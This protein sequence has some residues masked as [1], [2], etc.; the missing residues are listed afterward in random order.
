[1]NIPDQ[2]MVELFVGLNLIEGSRQYDAV[3]DAAEITIRYIAA[4]ESTPREQWKFLG[5]ES[6]YGFDWHIWAL[7]KNPSQHHRLGQ[8]FVAV[9]K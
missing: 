1:M 5:R 6:H 8:R 7:V 9:V 3:I 2:L 4:Q